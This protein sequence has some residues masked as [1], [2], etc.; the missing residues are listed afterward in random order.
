ML[1]AEPV[2]VSHSGKNTGEQEAVSC[3]FGFTRRPLFEEVPECR[4][5]IEYNGDTK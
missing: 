5:Q 2:R 3:V 4:S 1:Q